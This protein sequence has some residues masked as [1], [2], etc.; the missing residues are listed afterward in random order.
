MRL[1]Y[2]PDHTQ[3]IVYFFSNLDLGIGSEE[4]LGTGYVPPLKYGQRSNDPFL[5]EV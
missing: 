2:G 4:S 3:Y 5:D 1:S